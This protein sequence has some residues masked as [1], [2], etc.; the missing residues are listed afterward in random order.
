MILTALKCANEANPARMAVE[1]RAGRAGSAR[2]KPPSR[3]GEHQNGANE[4]TPPAQRGIGAN[5]AIRD[6]I[7][8]SD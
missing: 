7:A 1:V 5:E 8:Q 4:A 2:T 6:V 3:C